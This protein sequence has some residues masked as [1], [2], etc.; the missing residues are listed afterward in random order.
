MLVG[1]VWQIPILMLLGFF[2]LSTTPVL[3]ALVNRIKT[4][5]PAF[6]NGVFMTVNFAVGALAI[7]ITG[8][9]G[10]LLSLELTFKI[11][12]FLSAGSLIFA[13]LLGKWDQ[14]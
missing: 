1:G 3:L 14:N 2:V 4:S 9:L 5:H 13:L 8:I 10:D 11:S 6:L 12:A 7:M